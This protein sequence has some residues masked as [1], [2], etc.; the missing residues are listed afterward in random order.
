MTIA[1]FFSRLPL[2]FLAL[3]A[4]A[5]PSIAQSPGALPCLFEVVPGSWKSTSIQVTAGQSVSIQA[6]GIFQYKEHP[7]ISFPPGG[8]MYGIWSLKAKVGINQIEV[9]GAYGGFVAK[10]SGVLELG[11]PAKVDIPIGQYVDGL[12]SST[13]K[14]CVTAVNVSG[15][16]TLATVRI[17]T[18]QSCDAE[19]NENAKPMGGVTVTIGGKTVTTDANGDASITLPPSQSSVSARPPAGSDAVFGYAYRVGT[20]YRPSDT[21]G[22]DLKSGNNAVEVRMINCDEKGRRKARATIAEIGGRMTLRI[23]RAD[24]TV[25]RQAAGVGLVLRDG[26][27]L[28]VDGTGKLSWISGG[29]VEFRG[30]STTIEIGPVRPNGA[31]EG[32]SITKGLLQFWLDPSREN[33]TNR[34]E[35]GTRTVIVAVKGTI[36]TLGYDE[37]TA[38]ST[39]GVQEGSVDVIPTNRSLGATVLPAGRQLQVSA[40]TVQQVG[41]DKVAASIAGKW[42]FRGIA[43]QVCTIIVKGGGMLQLV[44]EKG[45]LGEGS[46]DDA[47]TISVEFPFG[48]VVGRITPDGNRINWSNGEFWTRLQ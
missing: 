11:A 44:T 4:L 32:V 1:R 31:P 16:V 8:D 7:R 25:L 2:L 36:F 6:T 34:F 48:D 26:D 43:G 23:R 13:S 14:Y 3:T 45:V 27:I 22:V 12:D 39:V 29:T 35:A 40:T 21:S 30:R 15:G 17:K 33:K 28:D 42:L 20:I 37:V 47:N 24:G 38:T 9:V 18:T 41:A 5:A 10:E 46:Q 19:D